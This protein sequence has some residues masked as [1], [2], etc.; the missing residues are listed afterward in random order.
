MP[1]QKKSQMSNLQKI[2]MS[3]ENNLFNIMLD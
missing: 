2:L 1:E 3:N